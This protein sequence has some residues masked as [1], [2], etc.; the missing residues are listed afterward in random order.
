MALFELFGLPPEL[1][2]NSGRFL[3]PWVKANQLRGIE[4]DDGEFMRMA[5]PDR[6]RGPKRDDAVDSASLRL[7]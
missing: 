3:A 2:L 1:Q 5:L 6:I 7:P 4:E